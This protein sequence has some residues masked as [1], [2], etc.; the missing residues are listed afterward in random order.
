MGLQCVVVMWGLCNV[1]GCNVVVVLF[2]VVMWGLQCGVLMWGLYCGIEIW[3][4]YCG[5][6]MRGGCNVGF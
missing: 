3:W 1:G 2:G 6:A 5:G 4:L